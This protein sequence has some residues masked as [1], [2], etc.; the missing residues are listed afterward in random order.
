M[1]SN[2]STGLLPSI[3]RAWMSI[4]SDLYLWNF[5][6]KLDIVNHLIFLIKHFSRDLA[7]YDA[8]NNTILHVDIVLPKAGFSYVILIFD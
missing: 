7:Y 8:I 4:D 1:Q 5:E 2:F 6:N 3:M